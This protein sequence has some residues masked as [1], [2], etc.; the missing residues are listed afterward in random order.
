MRRCSLVLVFLIE[1]VFG[2]GCAIEPLSKNEMAYKLRGWGK[3]PSGMPSS[4]RYEPWTAAYGNGYGSLSFDG[5][6]SCGAREP[7]YAQGLGLWKQWYDASG[8]SVPSLTP[9]SDFVVRARMTADHGGQAWF[10]IACGQDAITDQLNWTFLERSSTDRSHHF[11]PSN[12]GIYAW[13]T[14]EAATS[15]SG[16]TTASYAVPASFSCP[17]GRAVG[18]WLWKTGNTCIDADNLGRNTEKFVLSEHAAVIRAFEPTKAV[19]T[20]CTIPPE[21][22]ISCYDFLIGGSVPPSPSSLPSPLPSPSPRAPS[23]VPAPSPSP[24]RPTPS[25]ASSAPSPAPSPSQSSPS[26]TDSTSGDCVRQEDCSISAWCKDPTYIDWC[27]LQAQSDSSWCPSPHCIRKSSGPNPAPTPSPSS[28]C[29]DQALTGAWGGGGTYTC[30]TFKTNGGKAYCAHAALASACCFCKDDGQSQ[31]APVPTPEPEPEPAPEPAPASVPTPQPEPEPEPVP[32]NCTSDSDCPDGGLCCCYDVDNTSIPA[33][34]HLGA[35]SPSPRSCMTPMAF[36]S[37]VF[38]VLK[39]A[40]ALP[41]RVLAATPTVRVCVCIP[42]GTSCEDFRNRWSTTTTTT[43]RTAVPTTTTSGGNPLPT[44]LPT[45]SPLPSASPSPA[46]CVNHSVL[47]CINDASSYWPKCDPSQT[48]GAKGPS[49]YAYGHYCTQEWANALNEMLS[50]PAINKC[51]DDEGKRKLLAQIAYETAYFSTVYQPRDGGAGLIHMIPGNWVRNA[52]DMDGIWPGKGYAPLASVMG[53]KFFQQPEYGWRSVAAWFKKT[54]EVIPGCGLDLF[55]QP[56]QMQTRC[57]L[58]RIVS[59]QEAYDIVTRCMKQQQSPIPTPMPSPSASPQPAPALS[60]APQPAP[61]PAP[62]N[63]PPLAPS[64]S[65]QPSPVSGNDVV[66]AVVKQLQNTDSNNLFLYNTGSRWIQ[67][68]LYK[69]A[70]MIVAV[71]LM[72]VQGVGK[73]KLWLGGSVSEINYGLV[74]IAAFL[75]Q[76]MQETIQYNACDENNWSDPAV[77]AQAGGSA[78]SATSACGQLHQSYQ[79]YKCSAEENA[80]AGGSMECPVNPNME[81]RAQTQ[82]QWYGAPPKLFCA[83]RSKVPKAPRWDYLGPWCPP[84]DPKFPDDVSLGDY[85]TYVNGGGSCKDYTGIKSGG[86]KYT[87]SGC[88]NGA[89]PGSDAPKFG[90]PAGRTDVEGCCWWGRGVIQTTGVCNYGKLNY[91]LGKRAADENRSAMYPSIDF[92]TDPDIICSPDG[93]KELKWVAG[94]FY[95]LNAV[96]SYSAGGWNYIEELKKWVDGGRKRG[97]TSFI[98]GVSGIVNRGCHNPPNCGTGHLHAGSARAQNFHKV[99]DAM[100]L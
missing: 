29:Q 45:P 82:A 62:S 70:D 32:R 68:D 63:Q 92:C 98:N 78:Y 69:W 50:D 99:L 80:L 56:Y 49:G 57:I 22:F 8:T 33:R 95:W 42:T 27:P 76:T 44:P 18:R 12:P 20:K 83:P 61:T 72:A 30:A 87:G 23:P 66:D 96:Q 54:N 19:P 64:P 53:E 14:N 35:S 16:I 1:G 28:N 73:A 5:G 84:G 93:P 3:F 46:T 25:P 13:G 6:A 43:D 40:A 10:M 7:E 89:C 51:D 2:H 79:D 26:P 65:Q 37:G 52:V 55:D 81:K 38:S 48:K 39:H 86:W 9:G 36:V 34:G 4:F 15:M 59:R 75:A 71:R 77:V 47:V 88:V 60:P 31:P 91:F 100:K 67:S 94:L 90:Q 24:S 74:S 41:T 21:V 11:L 17:G 58:S 97:D 85:F